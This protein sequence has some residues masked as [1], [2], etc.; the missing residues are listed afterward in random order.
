MFYFLM[1]RFNV[2]GAKNVTLLVDE[3]N[4][5]LQN[6]LKE[7]IEKGTYIIGD[8]IVPETFEMTKIRNNKIVVE[9]VTIH[10]KKIP[11]AKIRQKMLEEHLCYM[12]LR[13]HNDFQN[14][15]GDEIINELKCLGELP[16]DD[17]LSNETLVNKLKSRR[18]LMFWHDG[19][20]LANHSHIL[21]TVAAVYD[22]AGYFRDEQ[23]FRKIKK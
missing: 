18:Q 9:D 14:L 7:S 20:T 12:R 1:F 23:F 15:T 4:E 8:L 16:N 5:S 2:A 3:I 21:M 11:M 6:Q 22:P 10:A 17:S 13:T 19:S